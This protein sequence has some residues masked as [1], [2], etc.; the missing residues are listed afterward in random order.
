MYPMAPSAIR[1]LLD[2]TPAIRNLPRRLSPRAS[3][4]NCATQTERVRTVTTQACM[5][6]ALHPY[7]NM[8][9]TLQ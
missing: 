8:D 5:V 3:N 4:P 9:T 1:H 7:D 2:D 6:A